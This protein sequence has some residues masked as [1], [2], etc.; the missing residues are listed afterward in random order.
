LFPVTLTGEVL[1]YNKTMFDKLGLKA[2]TTWTEVE[3]CAK[4]IH[5]A[6]GIAGFGTDSVTDT[7][8]CLIMQAGSNY[9]DTTKKSVAIDRQ[10]G[11][12]KLNWFA[13][14]IKAG[15]FRLVG[16]D[17]YFSNPFGSQ[18]VGMYIGSSAGID[19][20]KAAIP[21]D[22]DGHFEFACCPVPQE[23]PVKYISN[24]G[25]G[26][27]CLSKDEEHARGVYEF[28]KYFQSTE[29][30]VKWAE[31][32]G[33]VPVYAN[34]LAD[35]GFKQFE[36]NNPALGALSDEMQYVGYLP[37]PAGSETVRTEID[38]MIQLVSLGQSDAEAAYDAFINA[39]NAALND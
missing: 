30:A 25:V 39:S 22:G 26:Y 12:D 13:N 11:I 14:G 1:F 17:Q 6:Y 38:K 34:A 33:S 18:A 29:V 10:I 23:G 31:E 19:Y 8:Q 35:A 21:A 5:D 4:A 15:Y 28:L 9:I 36:E 37:C 27:A 2:P 32:F 3:T 24:W 20:V 16:E 7:Y